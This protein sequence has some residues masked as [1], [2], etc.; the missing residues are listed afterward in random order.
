V[1]TLT[2]KVHSQV[3]EAP[4]EKIRTSIPKSFR[5]D[6]R[7]YFRAGLVERYQREAWT[8]RY[9][10]TQQFPDQPMR[11]HNWQEVLDK[12]VKR[13]IKTTKAPIVER[14]LRRSYLNMPIDENPLW[15]KPDLLSLG[16]L[17]KP[18]DNASFALMLKERLRKEPRHVNVLEYRSEEAFGMH[19]WSHLK[20]YMKWNNAFPLDLNMWEDAHGKFEARRAALSASTKSNNVSRHEPNDLVRIYAKSQLKLKSNEV[21]TAKALQT[22]VIHSEQYVHKFGPT[23]VYLLGCLL[24]H[25]P[26]SVY[27]HAGQ[28]YQDMMDWTSKHAPAPPEYWESDLEQQEKSMSGAYV[29]LF[30]KVLEHFGVPRDI[31]EA[32][33]DDKLDKKTARMHL[34]LMTFSGEIFTFLANTLGNMARIAAKYDLKPAERGKFGGDDSLCYRRLQVNPRYSEWEPQDRAVEKINVYHTR[35]SFVGFIEQQGWVF[36]DPELLLRKLEVN[37][38]RGKTKDVLLGYT[39]DWLT[40]YRLGDFASVILTPF[41]MECQSVLGNIL[42]NSRRKLGYQKIIN[43]HA[44][45][46]VLFNNQTNYAR[47]WDALHEAVKLPDAEAPDYREL[48]EIGGEDL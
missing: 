41:E 31:I 22:I 8:D 3:I 2:K 13:T 20:R 12:E 35:G 4:D 28:S 39:L 9:G 47:Y 38:E 25:K 43:W 15:F 7:E 18:S 23:G 24:K 46:V 19:L 30:S 45:P 6:M 36:K 37:V 34:G 26:E 5:Q 14:R 44:F 17:Q 29:T 32:Y 27:I 48:D 1:K 42:F 21:K 33:I 16:A 10:Y 11:L 40:I